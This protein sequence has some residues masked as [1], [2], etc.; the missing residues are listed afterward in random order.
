MKKILLPVLALILITVLSLAGCGGADTPRQQ[1]E[2]EGLKIVT[3]LS[4]L[5]DLTENIVGWRGDVHYIVPIGENP[6]DYELLPSEF[7]RATDADV[8]FINGLNL[9][10]MIERV[11]KSATETKIVHL[12]EGITPIPLVGEEAA[13]PHAW[14]DAQLAVTYVDNI[15]DTL[16]ELDPAGEEYYRAN[17]AAYKEQL[18]ELDA[19]IKEQ[20]EQ[21]PEENRVIVVSENALK[22]YGRAYGF[23]TEGI[24]ELNAHEEGTPQQISR[25]VD[26]VKNRGIPALFAETTL[27]KRYIKMISK[28]TGVPI[29]GEVYT[30]ALGKPGSGAETYIG[31]MRHNTQV[32][33][34]GLR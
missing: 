24:W 1:A 5:A 18:L 15:L 4:I 8:I 14:L 12:T 9:E 21:V 30:D 2:D 6:E 28:E 17:A 22:Y 20:V 29:A 25:I 34:E 32:F 3:S 27:D 11:L 19:W 23:Q 26:L 16:V 31:M 10:A 7:Q 13:D 33:I